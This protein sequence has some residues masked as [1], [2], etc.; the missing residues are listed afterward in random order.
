MVYWK[1]RE[2]RKEEKRVAREIIKGLRIN[3]LCSVSK[4]K[5]IRNL[6]FLIAENKK[7]KLISR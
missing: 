7:I 5:F 6:S 1:N 4:F 2:I 3:N